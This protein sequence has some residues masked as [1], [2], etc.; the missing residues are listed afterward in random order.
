M[1]VSI[2][3]A[4]QI[5]SEEPTTSRF[6]IITVVGQG[7]QTRK[8]CRMQRLGHATYLLRA[9]LAVWT[10]PSLPFPSHAWLARDVHQAMED[11]NPAKAM[12]SNMI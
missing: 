3:L 5:L 10:F 12:F 4:V 11:P 8:L 1:A 2:L 6:D 9:Q 7:G